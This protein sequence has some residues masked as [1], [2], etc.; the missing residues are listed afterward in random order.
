MAQP[1]INPD[2]NCTQ[3]SECGDDFLHQKCSMYNEKILAGYVDYI[4]HLSHCLDV[5][6]KR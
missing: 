2:K 6:V 4:G 1:C 5:Y 3:C